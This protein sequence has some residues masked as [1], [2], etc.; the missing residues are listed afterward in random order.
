MLDTSVTSSGAKRLYSAYVRTSYCWISVSA[1]YAWTP[2]EKKLTPSE[3][4]AQS[5]PVTFCQ[6][7]SGCVAISGRLAR[8]DAIQHPIDNSLQAL[9]LRR[10]LCMLGAIP[11]TTT[12]VART[13][14]ER[15]L[16]QLLFASARAYSLQCP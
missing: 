15:G 1:L 4:R 12:I 8:T 6:A 7:N 16:W 13:L 5:D 14:L 2:P 9:L 10:I 11:E 3:L